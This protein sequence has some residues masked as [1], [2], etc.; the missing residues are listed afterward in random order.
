MRA[1]KCYETKLIA[2]ATTTATATVAPTTAATTICRQFD[3]AKLAKLM[4]Q[5]LIGYAERT[6]L[7]IA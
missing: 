5:L 4:G 6:D 2:K 3:D 1:A 7:D